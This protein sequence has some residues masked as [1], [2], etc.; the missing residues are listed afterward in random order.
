MNSTMFGSTLVTAIVATWHESTLSLFKL[1][2]K[3]RLRGPRTITASPLLQHRRQETYF[4]PLPPGLVRWTAI[5]L[6]HH[7]VWVPR[8]GVT[9]PEV[10]QSPKAQGHLTVPGLAGKV[11]T[12]TDILSRPPSFFNI[13]S[14]TLWGSF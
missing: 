2:K 11:F 6:F 9:E 3:G 5:R 7:E 10:T 12:R 1:P 13:E 8:E 14:V 4:T